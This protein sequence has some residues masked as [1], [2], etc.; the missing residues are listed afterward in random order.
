M[1]A[2]MHTKSAIYV[3]GVGRFFSRLLNSLNCLS[4]IAR[5]F[6]TWVIAICYRFIVLY[7]HRL[8]NLY[9]RAAVR[10]HKNGQTPYSGLYIYMN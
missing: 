8:V 3:K 7:R 2:N 6:L 9:L 10:W 5:P 1:T 4:N